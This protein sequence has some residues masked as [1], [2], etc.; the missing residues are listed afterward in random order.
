M[1]L[2]I[3]PHNRFKPN[4]SI[5]FQGALWGAPIEIFKSIHSF[6]IYPIE[7]KLGRTILNTSPHNLT[8]LFDDFLP[9][10]AVEARILKSFQSNQSIQ[11]L[12]DSA[13]TW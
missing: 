8:K 2:E 11:L 4:F 13:E 5:S 6:S 1:I 9:E 12:S 10:K 3:S 7:L